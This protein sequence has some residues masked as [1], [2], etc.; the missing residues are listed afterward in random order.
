MG[1]QRVEPPLHSLNS[2]DGVKVPDLG[3]AVNRDIR[4]VTA[5]L[6]PWEEFEFI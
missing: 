1:A 4:K 5:L 3:E 6:T 2:R